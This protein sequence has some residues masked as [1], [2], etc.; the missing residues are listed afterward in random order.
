MWIVDPVQDAMICVLDCH[1]F[2]NVVDISLTKISD[3][4]MKRQKEQLW[5][6]N[7]A[8]SFQF[9]KGFFTCKESMS[10]KVFAVF[11]QDIWGKAN[12]VKNNWL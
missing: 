11:M 3:L 2:L 6:S 1:A 10:R 4:R 5:K 12:V 9:V 8:L 7:E